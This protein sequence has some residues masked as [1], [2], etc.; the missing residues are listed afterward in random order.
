VRELARFS[1]LHAYDPVRALDTQGDH[2][3]DVDLQARLT[4]LPYTTF[5]YD[6]T[7][8]VEHGHAASTRVGGYITDPRPL[9]TPTSLL[10]HLQRH[11]TLGLSYQ[12]I[13]GEIL[14]ELDT[15]L[16][17]RVNDQITA[18]FIARYDL[19]TESF[20]GD[21]YY[22]RYIAPQKCWYVDL[23]AIDKV[24]PHEFEFRVTFT[25]LGLGTAPHEDF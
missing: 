18:A 20:I 16:I 22:L 7:Y 14:K 1:V 11:T 12:T 4:P 2:F 17:V 10:Q 5:T 8:D 24:N 15:R 13:S 25:L 9:P 23:G 21:R 6:S 19:H 3:S